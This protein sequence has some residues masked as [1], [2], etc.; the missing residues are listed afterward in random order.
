M[1]AVCG[2]SQPRPQL[3]QLGRQLERSAQRRPWLSGAFGL[4]LSEAMMFLSKTMDTSH[5]LL[6]DEIHNVLIDKNLDPD[7]EASC[8]QE[9]MRHII[10]SR[11]FQSE[12]TWV[13]ALA[14]VMNVVCQPR[15]VLFGMPPYQ[16]LCLFVVG[17][18]GALDA[19][20][21]VCAF[22]CCCV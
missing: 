20:Q 3:Q 15:L 7:D 4:E 6:I 16:S 22:V 9:L 19:S 10:E 12:S 13:R 17:F 14:L 11:C 18:L 8:P 5:P 2:Q 21:T 1:T